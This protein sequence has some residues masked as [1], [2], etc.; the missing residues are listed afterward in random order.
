MACVPPS[1]RVEQDAQDR[2]DWKEVPRL[3]TVQTPGT[4][5]ILPVAEVKLDLS[6]GISLPTYWHLSS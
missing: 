6:T 5:G 1:P 4:V 3:I 2:V